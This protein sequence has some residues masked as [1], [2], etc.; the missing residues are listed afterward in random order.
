MR[1]LSTELGK[2]ISGAPSPARQRKLT[3][4]ECKIFRSLKTQGERSTKG[5]MISE[6]K[7][8]SKATGRLKLMMV[9]EG[10]HAMSV[11]TQVAKR[12]EQMALVESAN[13]I[14]TKNGAS[15]V[16]C[17]KERKQ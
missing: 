6:C 2:I 1:K 3:V 12:F 8:E 7:F 10:R 14:K 17:I 13:L 9:M 4:E 15:V 5:R 11:G 16:L